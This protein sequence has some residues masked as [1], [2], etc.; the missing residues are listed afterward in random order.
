MPSVTWCSWCS[1]KCL[2]LGKSLPWSDVRCFAK[3]KGNL[4][5]REKIGLVLL[6]EHFLALMSVKL[7]LGHLWIPQRT[8]GTL[9]VYSLGYLKLSI[10]T[11]QVL[12]PRHWRIVFFS[13]F[14]ALQWCGSLP[15]A[16]YTQTLHL[17]AVRWKLTPSWLRMSHHTQY[18]QERLES[19]PTCFE[20]TGE[21]IR[22]TTRLSH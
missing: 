7:C 12:W 11:V 16:R 13:Q 20:N 5:L 2:C 15:L 3:Y 9:T 6:S 22:Q 19:S 21:N 10:F 1:F 17:G 4:I 8:L 14:C 18:T